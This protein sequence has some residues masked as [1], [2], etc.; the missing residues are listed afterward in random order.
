MLDETDLSEMRVRRL[1]APDQRLFVYVIYQSP[2]RE[3]VN[4]VGENDVG[5]A[6]SRLGDNGEESERDE[7]EDT[8]SNT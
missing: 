8:T 1:E 6:R 5:D 2:W 4:K 7:H 3:W